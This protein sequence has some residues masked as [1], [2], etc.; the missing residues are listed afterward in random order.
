MDRLFLLHLTC[1]GSI[2]LI[3]ISSI[4]NITIAYGNRLT[5]AAQA[6]YSDEHGVATKESEDEYERNSS[7][8]KALLFVCNTVGLFIAALQVWKMPCLWKGH[9][10]WAS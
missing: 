9:I 10:F 8:P 4:I 7:L 3:T 2:T 6:R 1:L 5:D